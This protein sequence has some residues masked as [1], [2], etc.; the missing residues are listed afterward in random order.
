MTLAR[1][2]AVEVRHYSMSRPP[3]AA[4]PE[5]TLATR[6]P[7]ALAIDVARFIRADGTWLGVLRDFHGHIGARTCGGGAAPHP[8]TKDALELRA[9]LCEALAAHLFNVVLTPNHNRPHRN[10]FH[11]EV[12]PGV[13]WFLYD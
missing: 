1:H 8:A 9:I 4:W 6:H 7:G 3:S 10:H 5:G 11:M 12:T 13:R 2:A